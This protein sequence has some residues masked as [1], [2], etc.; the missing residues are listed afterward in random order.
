[1][2]CSY[3][4]QI[5]HKSSPHLAARVSGG[6]QTP[7]RRYTSASSPLDNGRRGGG[8]GMPL[9]ATDL[10]GA[11]CFISIRWSTKMYPIYSQR[12][13]YWTLLELVRVKRTCLLIFL[14]IEAATNSLQIRG[15]IWIVKQGEKERF[16]KLAFFTSESYVTIVSIV[17]NF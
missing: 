17:K 4:H 13:F 1:M 3:C 6:G 2:E 15:K 16:F 10:L 9:L 8:T 14:V 7:W 11:N 5:S 12:A